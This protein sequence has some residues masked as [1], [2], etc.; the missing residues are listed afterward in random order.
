MDADYY[1]DISSKIKDDPQAKVYRVVHSTLAFV[2]T[3]ILINYLMQY[4]GGIFAYLLG[5]EPDVRYFG[6][7]NMPVS[8]TLWTKWGVLFIYGIAPFL[9]FFAGLGLYKLNAIIREENTIFKVYA[10]WGGIH[11][12]LLFVSFCITSAFGTDAYQLPFYFGIAVVTTWLHIDSVLVAPLALGGVIF[13]IV[14]GLNI[15]PTF[16]SLSFSRTLAINYRSRRQF[17]IE[18]AVIPWILGS[19]ITMLLSMPPNLTMRDVL[20]N[21]SKT[22]AFAIVI[23]G[24]LFKLDHIVGKLQIHS[25]DVFKRPIWPVIVALVVLVITIQRHWLSLLFG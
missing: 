24:M 9:T 19:I 7:Y 5:Y 16:L 23:L 18:V 13:L 8:P 10:L 3:Y 14:M 2:I 21:F 11:G 1:N 25:F 12:M 15:V 4:L 17:F 22:G 6:I 20:L